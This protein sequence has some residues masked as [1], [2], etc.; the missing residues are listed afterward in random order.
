[1]AKKKKD[2]SEIE[3]RIIEYLMLE[4][5]ARCATD[6]AKAI[7]FKSAKDV[8]NRLNALCS[9]KVI[10][11]IKDNHRVL[12]SIENSQP[13]EIDGSDE[14]GDVDIPLVG[15]TSQFEHYKYRDLLMDTLLAQV[16]DLKSTV[17]FLREEISFKN[18][19]I[20]CLMKC[21][22][23][24]ANPN[25]NPIA[26]PKSSS[27]QEEG[28]FTSP[29][30]TCRASIVSKSS[31]SFISRNQFECLQAVVDEREP[32]PDLQPDDDDGSDS[33]VDDLDTISTSSS[34]QSSFGHLRN[35]SQSRHQ[36][37]PRKDP[38]FLNQRQKAK[39]KPSI[40][41]TGDSMLKSLSGYAVRQAVPGVDAHVTPNLGAMVED[42][43]DKMAPDIRKYDP[44]IV[45]LHVG[46]NDCRFG[47]D[48]ISNALAH[49]ENILL[50]L[51]ELSIIPIVSLNFSDKINFHL[52][53]LFNT[54]LI[55]L[56]SKLKVNFY[57]NENINGNSIYFN[58][59]GHLNREGTDLLCTNVKKFIDFLLP[60]IYVNNDPYMLTYQN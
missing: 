40:L 35:L 29:K 32:E 15:E 50:Y 4:T 11:R 7:G 39:K 38:P 52:L 25:A 54:R 24:E 27:S 13:S 58:K 20:S 23:H 12:W 43:K 60:Q 14:Q 21:E 18:S 44:D 2:Y 28:D 17:T 57:F 48:E 8:T 19:L 36:S 31:E 16:D 3:S 5:N 49:Y 59:G 26:N 42:M 45:V 41:V 10:R 53:K 22:T 37:S 1:M 34:V 47:V 55:A 6:I 30:R 51:D 9:R 33:R 46:I 56:C